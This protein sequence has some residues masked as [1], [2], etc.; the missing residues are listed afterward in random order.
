MG[1]PLLVRAVRT[2][3]ASVS[4][5]LHEAALGLGFSKWRVFLR[6]TLPLAS[7]GIIA[8]I[9]LAF[10]RSLGE[11]GATI[12]FAGVVPGETTTLSV[13]I[14]ATLQQPQSDGSLVVLLLASI[15]L[16]VIAVLISEL[17]MKWMVRR[18]SA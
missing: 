1:F 15:G 5:R 18:G 6:I 2:G 3:I 13:A 10:A 9:A 14:F 4:P 11:F 7:P 8:G 12:T 17:L 16:S